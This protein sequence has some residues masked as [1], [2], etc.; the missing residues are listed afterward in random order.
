MNVIHA[1][2]GLIFVPGTSLPAK[3]GRSQD[4]NVFVSA[5]NSS[6]IQY[7][8]RPSSGNFVLPHVVRASHK[9]TIWIGEILQTGGAIWRLEIQSGSNDSEIGDSNLHE[10]KHQSF[11]QKLPVLS[12]GTT[13]STPIS[14]FLILSILI[15]FGVFILCFC[16]KRCVTKQDSG[17]SQQ[18]S[19]DRKVLL[20]L[21]F[22]ILII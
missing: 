20:F 22:S 4:I 10:L 5:R 9:K 16:C 12:N 13:F 2:V 17:P 3:N 18:K 19:F 7:S 14:A 21:L 15:F 11:M 1:D 6:H 8:F